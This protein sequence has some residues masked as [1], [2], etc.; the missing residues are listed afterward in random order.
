MQADCQLTQVIVSGGQGSDE[1]ISEAASM[2][3]YLIQNQVEAN[4]IQTEALSTSTFENIK[5]SK[6]L[7]QS[8]SVVL[9]S[10]DFHVLR[11]KLIANRLGL[12]VDTLAAPTPKSVRIQLYIREY[13]ALIKSFLFDR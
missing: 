2:K 4:R 6:K 8:E 3:R 9:V 10:N 12:H 5:F 1:L 11:A 7:L 13:I